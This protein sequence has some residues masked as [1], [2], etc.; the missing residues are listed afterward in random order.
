MYWFFLRL[1]AKLLQA[2]LVL[3][4]LGNLSFWL[5]I[6][7]KMIE[8]LNLIEWSLIDLRFWRCAWWFLVLFIRSEMHKTSFDRSS[9]INCRSWN[10]TDL[11]HYVHLGSTLY[12]P[13]FALPSSTLWDCSRK[14]KGYSFSFWW[15]NHL[16]MPLL[17]MLVS[18][19]ANLLNWYGSSAIP[20]VNFCVLWSV[21]LGRSFHQWW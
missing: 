18:W 16:C 13:W 5:I 7:E 1:V 12:F 21:I 17:A 8:M 15:V 14:K 6:E 3:I 20:Q 4:S 9:Q 2:G 19:R 10:L 11:S